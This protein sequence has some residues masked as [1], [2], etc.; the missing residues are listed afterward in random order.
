MAEEIKEVPDVLVDQE[1][2]LENWKILAEAGYTADELKDLSK[3]ELEGILDSARGGDDEKTELTPE[4]LA[5]I[6][7]GEETEEA[8]ALRLKAEKEAADAKALEDEAKAKGITVEQLKT[9]KAAAVVAV[10]VTPAPAPAGQLTDDDLLDFEPV[11]S[12]SEIVVEY[13]PPAELQA[14]LDD[15]EAKLDTGEIQRADY[16]KQRDEIRDT[17]TDQRQ[18]ARDA[19][20]E[21]L[22]WRKEQQYFLNARTEYLGDKKADGKF[23]HNLKSKTLMGALREA[24]STISAD[25]KNANFSGMQLLIEADK[26]VKDA[27]GIKPAAA[28]PAGPAAP[29]AKPPAKLPDDQTLADI[30]ASAVN[31]TSGAFD[32]LD[33]LTGEAYEEALARLPA[34][35]RNAYLDDSRPG[36]IG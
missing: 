14:K 8:K 33:K 23:V 4:Q 7:A 35:M 28:A 12:A 22:V 5:A 36:R 1:V 18:A 16:N 17:I 13:K 31:E 29:P 32:E 15:L 27:F 25:P 26:A 20:R 19:A 24:V 9:E 6:A 21:D 34:R 30:P 10:E 2:T 11:I 3:D